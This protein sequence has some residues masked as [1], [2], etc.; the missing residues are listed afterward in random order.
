MENWQVC[1]VK[2]DNKIIDAVKAIDSS[3]A[4][5]ALITDDNG[6]LEGV[7]TDYDV[8]QALLK[9]KSSDEEVTNIMSANPK[10]MADD[11][12]D[13]DI[14]AYMKDRNVRQVPLLDKNRKLVG[15]KIR[16][17]FDE[18]TIRRTNPVV[19][20]AGGLGTRLRPLTDNCPKPL[21]KIGD[22]PILERILGS[23]IHEG[24]RDF[25][26]SVN[27]KAE[28]IEDYF[29]DGSQWNIK[30]NYLE[31]DKRLGTAGALSL[32]PDNL[33]EP[34]IVM[35]GDLL[36]KVD[37]RQLLDFHYNR[38][39]EATMCV[40][41]YKYQIPY[42]VINFNDWRIGEIQE[43]PI[44]SAFVNAGIYVLNPDVIQ[45]IP[46]DTYYDMTTLF[47]SLIDEDR[48]VLGF[49]IREYWMDVGQMDDF[50]KA[51]TEFL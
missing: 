8:R 2:K 50:R 48:N 46:N 22:K 24:F 23:F 16:S 27:Y 1:I 44:E 35:N 17:D 49:P 13:D 31:E 36:T 39:S 7:I 33:T 45:A 21:L 41:E 43:K 28:M 47:N 10:T 5:I 19:I 30:I 37:F 14:L 11:S 4:K 38:K 34:V 9:G 20:M 15:L 3:C 26:I 40:R 12:T 42:G 25:F 29:G 51:G 6:V 18:S 32:L